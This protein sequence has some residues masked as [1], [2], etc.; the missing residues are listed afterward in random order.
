MLMSSGRVDTAL[1]IPLKIHIAQENE[2]IVYFT[3][4]DCTFIT[5]I[6]LK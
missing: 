4:K 1:N 5:F 2:N 6:L 3:L